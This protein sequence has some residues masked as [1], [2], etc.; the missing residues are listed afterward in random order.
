MRLPFGLSL[1]V[2]GVPLVG[3]ASTR[4][5]GGSS[6]QSWRQRRGVDPYCMLLPSGFHAQQIRTCEPE[7]R[8]VLGVHT[9][10]QRIRQ[11][12]E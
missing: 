11:S 1:V 5:E 8:W 2:I 7:P 6:K 12:I 3:R 4:S 10:T 9:F